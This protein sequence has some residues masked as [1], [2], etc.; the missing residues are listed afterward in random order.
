MAALHLAESAPLDL[1]AFTHDT[2][3]GGL[4]ALVLEKCCGVV[5][6][7]LC[8]ISPDSLPR[9]F[10]QSQRLLKRRISL[11]HNLIAN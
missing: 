2:G 11:K 7:P 6:L 5:P 3:I 4:T 8:S 9:G 1:T 10:K